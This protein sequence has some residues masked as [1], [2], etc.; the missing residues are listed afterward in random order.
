MPEAGFV[1]QV[2]MTWLQPLSNDEVKYE[3]FPGVDTLVTV[4]VVIP[5]DTM[6]MGAAPAANARNAVARLAQNPPSEKRA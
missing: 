6:S 3:R 5:S 2:T 4:S 1:A